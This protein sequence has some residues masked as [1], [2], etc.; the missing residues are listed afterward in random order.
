MARTLSWRQDLVQFLGLCFGFGGAAHGTWKS[1][2][3]TVLTV[4]WSGL[5]A[6]SVNIALVVELICPKANNLAAS[7]AKLLITATAIAKSPTGRQG[8]RKIA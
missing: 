1:M 7:S 3:W 8:T 4:V 5:S 2:I 6:E